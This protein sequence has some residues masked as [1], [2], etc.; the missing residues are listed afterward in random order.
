ML[1][2]SITLQCR[3]TSVLAVRRAVFICS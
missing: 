3:A 1:V 2:S